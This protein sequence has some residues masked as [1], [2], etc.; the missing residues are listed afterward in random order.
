LARPTQ[1]FDWIYE[2]VELAKEAGYTERAACALLS[3]FFPSRHGRPD[4]SAEFLRNNYR[5]WRR[6]F[7]HIIDRHRAEHLKDF[8]A[9]HLLWVEHLQKNPAPLRRNRLVGKNP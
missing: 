9:K 2:C 7:G 3:G 6:R 1:D 4:L 5:A 8:A